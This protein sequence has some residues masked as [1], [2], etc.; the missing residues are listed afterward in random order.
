MCNKNP[1]TLSHLCNVETIRFFKIKT[2]KMK[3]PII[4]FAILAF[5]SFSFLTSCKNE[6]AQEETLETKKII[7]VKEQ[8]SLTDYQLFKMKI[9]EKIAANELKIAE[10]KV[11]VNEGNKKAKKQY[12]EKII[13]IEE[14]NKG[15]KVKVN[16]YTQ[17]NA[18]TWEAF[19]TG[20]QDNA[21]ELEKDLEEFNDNK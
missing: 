13:L 7:V 8:D 6:N 19:K 3:K 1:W 4:T 18:E 2:N 17:S 10:L 5:T 15:L 21:E 11:T 12:D 14:K 20:L 16:N 9:N